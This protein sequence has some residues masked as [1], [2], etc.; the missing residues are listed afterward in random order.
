MCIS[1][2][3]NG[4][5]PTDCNVVYYFFLP[6]MDGRTARKEFGPTLLRLDYN[7][8]RVASG[9]VILHNKNIYK[10]GKS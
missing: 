6:L 1:S 3:I 4:Y 5:L 2:D 9:N 8:W 7:I 10:R